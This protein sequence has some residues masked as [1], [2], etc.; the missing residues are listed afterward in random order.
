MV[1]LGLA[2]FL[3]IGLMAFWVLA[4]LLGFVLPF[5]ITIGVVDMLKPKRLEESAEG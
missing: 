3:I 2:L 1:A 4:F 5:W